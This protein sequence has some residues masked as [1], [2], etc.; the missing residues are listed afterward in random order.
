L[1]Q[2]SSEDAAVRDATMRPQELQT[3]MARAE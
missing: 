1:A 2:A 3:A